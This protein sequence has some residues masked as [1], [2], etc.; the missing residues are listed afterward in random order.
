MRRVLLAAA[1][2]GLVAGAAGAAVSAQTSGPVFKADGYL[3]I[4]QDCG[5]ASRI[6]EVKCTVRAKPAPAT[7]TTAVATTQPPTTQ[8]PTTVSPTTAPPTTASP[9]TAPPT[10]QPQTG[11]TPT[12]ASTGPTVSS[13]Q[14]V[15]DVQVYAGQTRVLTDVVA[16][17]VFVHPGGQLDMTRVR[18][19]GSVVMN[20]VAG[21]PTRLH[22]TDSSVSAGTVLNAVDSQGNLD[23]DTRAPVD[24]QIVDSFLFHPQGDGSYHTE[25]VAGFGRLVGLRFVNTALVQQGPFNST[26]TGAIN[27]YGDDHVFDRCWFGYQNGTAAYYTIYLRGQNN[28]VQNSTIQTGLADYVYPEMRATYVNNVDAETGQPINP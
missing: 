22:V 8:P 4:S 1:A 6:G 20:T 28:V 23:Y 24:V 14:H 16:S 13:P 2:L 3:V 15:G 26:A 25:A 17:S 19:E 11:T 18:V 7:T 10:T 27:L 12:F 9:T 21:Q 5:A